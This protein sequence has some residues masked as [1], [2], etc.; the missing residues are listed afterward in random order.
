MERIYISNVEEKQAICFDTGLDPRSFARTKMSQSL[1]ECGYIVYPDGSHE[2]WKSSGVNEINGNMVVW[3]TPFFG[4]RLDLLLSNLEFSGSES[5]QTAA[6]HGVLHWLRAKMFLGDTY[7]S[8]NP[9]ATFVIRKDGKDPRYPEG[10]VFFAPPA[11]S[12]R[13]LLVEKTESQT[14]QSSSHDSVK[15]QKK[16][17]NYERE[18]SSEIVPVL[19]RY[20][21]PDLIGMEATAFC[22]GAMLYK[23]LTKSYP[24]P[25]DETIFQDMREGIFLPPHLAA[26]ALNKNLCGII[27]SA[28]LCRLKKENR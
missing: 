15:R 1:I 21:C 18:I 25:S 19:D 5:L 17:K 2:V 4:D 8:L 20:S 9:G 26:T 28:L 27:N 10:S 22:A 6:L 3:G 14:K 12:N 11:L 23:I 16:T 7:S 24:Y 13:C